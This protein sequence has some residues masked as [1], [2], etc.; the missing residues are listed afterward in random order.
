MES[1]FMNHGFGDDGSLFFQTIKEQ[2]KRNLCFHTVM[3]KLKDVKFQLMFN[4]TGTAKDLALEMISLLKREA[5]SNLTPIMLDVFAPEIEEITI[6]FIQSDSTSIALKLNECRADLIG[7]LFKGNAKLIKLGQI[8]DT[9]CL[10]AKNLQKKQTIF[11][12]YQGCR[13]TTPNLDM[14][15]NKFYSLLKQISSQMEVV[16]G[17]EPTI[18]TMEIVKHLK[19][20]AFCCELLGDYETA[21]SLYSQ[22]KL[23][24][25][26]RFE[27]ERGCYKASGAFYIALIES[28]KRVMHC[29][30]KAL[31]IFLWKCFLVFAIVMFVMTALANGA[32]KLGQKLTE[33]GNDQD[34]VKPEAVFITIYFVVI[35]LAFMTIFSFLFESPSQEQ[36]P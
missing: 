7:K 9:M 4:Y 24:L 30:R 18:K 21:E 29:S 6:S 16:V 27:G 20:Y 17:A 12:P 14:E 31:Q 3:T 13:R 32:F 5:S 22:A 2:S 26:K 15:L 35:G 34:D 1:F 11:F 23:L 25:E 8:N 19:S 28:H 10:I 36:K 33:L